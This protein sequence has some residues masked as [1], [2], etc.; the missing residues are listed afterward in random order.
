VSKARFRYTPVKDKEPIGTKRVNS[1]GP[2][3]LYNAD[4]QKVEE[5][6]HECDESITSHPLI[7]AADLIR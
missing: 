3:P 5:K 4:I 6:W 1:T 7:T 2:E